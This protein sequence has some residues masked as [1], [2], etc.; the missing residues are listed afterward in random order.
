M[1]KTF[2]VSG[3]AKRFCNFYCGYFFLDVFPANVLATDIAK[4]LSPDNSYSDSFIS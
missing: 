1:D 2:A 3:S 4:V